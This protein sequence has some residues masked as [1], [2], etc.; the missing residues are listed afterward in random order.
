MCGHV[1]FVKEVLIFKPELAL[2]ADSQGLTPLHLAS[3]RL[4]L[5]LVKVLLEA[6]ADA[7]IVQDQDGRTPLHLAVMK[8]QGKAIKT[9]KMLIQERPEAIHIR[10]ERNETIL[11]FCV[12]NNGTVQALRLLVEYLAGEK[13]GNRDY[14]ISANSK[15][16]DGNTILH[17]AAKAGNMK[18]V[19][20]LVDSEIVRVDINALNNNGLKALDIIPQTKKNG[21]RNWVFLLL[22]TP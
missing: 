15:D 12:K 17:L 4:H 5:R 6:N 10:N 21:I 3:A 18:I 2:K 7:C 22:W 14:S 8:G 11:H 20:F 9:M 1:S 13:P 19:K 16:A